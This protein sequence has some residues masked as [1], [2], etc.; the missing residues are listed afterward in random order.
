MAVVFFPIPNLFG[1][2]PSTQYNQRKTI[3]P[4]PC[5]HF[6]KKNQGKGVLLML[7]KVLCRKYD[8]TIF[9]SWCF[10]CIQITRR[11]KGNTIYLLLYQLHD[12]KSFNKGN[13]YVHKQAQLK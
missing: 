6:I 7:N 10:D 8:C 11:D 13:A 5:F 12:N 2:L 3:P 1:I 9:K 4:P